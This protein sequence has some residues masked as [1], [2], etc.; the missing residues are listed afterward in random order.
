M[1][2]REESTGDEA[3]RGGS[4]WMAA[5]VITDEYIGGAAIIYF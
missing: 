4:R 3:S 2:E 1:K 5:P